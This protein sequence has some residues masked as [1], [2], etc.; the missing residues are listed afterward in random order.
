ME[1]AALLLAPAPPPPSLA[2]TSVQSQEGGSVNHPLLVQKKGEGMRGQRVGAWG[3]GY[4]PQHIPKTP[5]VRQKG[6]QQSTVGTCFPYPPSIV[7]PMREEK[8]SGQ[9]RKDIVKLGKN[10]GEWRGRSRV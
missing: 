7:T 9:E 4:G 3:G 2:H 10:S 8:R 5:A 1:D 6:P